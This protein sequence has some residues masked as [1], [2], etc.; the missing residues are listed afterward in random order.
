MPCYSFRFLVAWGSLKLLVLQSYSFHQVWNLSSI[1][2]NFFFSVS[3]PPVLQG[4]HLN[5]ILTCLKSFH[6]SLLLC[7]SLNDLYCFPILFFIVSN[8]IYSKCLLYPAVYIW[9]HFH[10]RHSTFHFSKFALQLF[11]NLPWLYL[12]FWTCGI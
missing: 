11:F 5:A 8:S 2:F 3:F 6:S 1:I 9:Y 10:L 4:F 7:S 12:T